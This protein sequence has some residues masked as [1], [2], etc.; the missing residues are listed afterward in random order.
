MNNLRGIALMV[1][2]MAGF[3][4]ADALIKGLSSQLPPGQII[5]ALGL[6]GVAFFAALMGARGKPMTGPWTLNRVVMTRNAIEAL[7]AIAFVTSL[8]LVDL[9]VQAAIIQATPL[10]VTLGGALLLRETVGWRRWLAVGLGLVGV[11]LIIR[12]DADGL[13]AGA[14]AAVLAAL[15]LAGRDL[16]TRMVPRDVPTEALGLYGCASLIVAAAVLWSIGPAF[17]APT[18]VQWV[19]LGAASAFGSLAYWAI[20]EAMRT[21]EVSVLAPFRYTRLLFAMAYGIL[22]FGERPDAW[23]LAGA[24]L[25]IASGLYALS[26]ER[27]RRGAE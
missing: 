20:T 19:K 18:P 12:P 25:I 10:L 9:S 4:T 27:K 13:S 24:G 26:R 23:V 2:A 21:G 6:G 7:A 14:L 3:A 17:V 5:L 8:S 22:I 16:A 1:L 11:L 15:F